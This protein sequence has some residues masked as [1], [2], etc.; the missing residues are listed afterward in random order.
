MLNNRKNK[1]NI[2]MRIRDEKNVSAMIRQYKVCR[3]S[4][5]FKNY[6]VKMSNMSTCSYPDFEK[7]GRR[8]KCKHI[9]F[10]L[11]H[12][13][14]VGDNSLIYVQ[15]IVGDDDVR[16]MFVRAPATVPAEFMI[17]RVSRNKTNHAEILSKSP[18]AKPQVWKLQVTRNAHCRSCRS[19]IAVGMK[20]LRVEGALN[21]PYGNDFAVEQVQYFCI[22]CNCITRFPAWT[23]ILRLTSITADETSQKMKKMRYLPYYL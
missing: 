7:N 14:L 2:S 21:I 17:E 23:N 1:V 6:Y 9:L 15:Q 11:K 20:C 19:E 8:V 22:K 3:S 18:L 13:L 4:Q 16:E 12:C 5:S 10:I